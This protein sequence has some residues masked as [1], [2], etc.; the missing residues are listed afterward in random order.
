M[1]KYLRKS[2]FCVLYAALATS[3]LQAVY[4]PHDGK[5]QTIINLSKSKIKTLD[6]QNNTPQTQEF[7]IEFMEQYP[8]TLLNAKTYTI[9]IQPNKTQ[10]CSQALI[11]AST[12]NNAFINSISASSALTIEFIENN[13]APTIL[14]CRNNIADNAHQYPIVQDIDFAKDLI[15]NLG[16]KTIENIFSPNN[17]FAKYVLAPIT[18]NELLTCLQ[19]LYEKNRLNKVAP[20]PAVSIPH[21]IH[22]IWLGS[23]FPEGYRPWRQTWLDKHPTWKYILWTD[24]KANHQEGIYIANEKELDAALKS[25]KFSGKTLVVN[26]NNIK[27]INRALFDGAQNYGEKS[28]LLRCEAL[29]RYGGTYSDT[30]LEC[31]EPFDVLHQTYDFYIGLAPLNVSSGKFQIAT[32]IIGSIPNHPI[33]AYNIQHATARATFGYLDKILYNGSSI[34]AATGPGLMTK[35]V[36]YKANENPNL[37]NIVFPASYFYALRC[38]M[39]QYGQTH[40]DFP[41]RLF[42]ELPGSFKMPLQTFATH[43]WETSWRPTNKALTPAKA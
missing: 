28:D 10:H 22:H 24:N 9:Q 18:P 27:L 43:Y 19:T 42:V 25:E 26:V 1:N 5:L 11:N 20:R 39:L 34:I 3:Q 30:D 33:L 16:N 17:K 6:I 32:G 40:D 41:P 12:K 4:E 36:F 29:Y 37:R 23:P 2:I 35:A 13:H 38:E 21:I 31:F 14:R 7:C 15:T 8:N